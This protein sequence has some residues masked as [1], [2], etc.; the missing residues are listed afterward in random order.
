M[1]V[2][3]G[4]RIRNLDVL[5]PSR[6]KSRLRWK[7]YQVLSLLV[8]RTPE[9]VSRSEIIENIW[10]GTYCSDSTINQTI[11][12]IRQKIGDTE[13][14][15]IRT[16]PRLGYKI[17]NKDFFH[18]IAEEDDFIHNEALLSIETFQENIQG[19]LSE[20]E[21]EVND[22]PYVE[23]NAEG[24]VQGDEKLP[25]QITAKETVSINST[26]GDS[27]EASAF[28]LTRIIKYL[29][30]FVMLLAISHLSYVLGSRT[31][32]PTLHGLPN[33][34]RL[35]L[36]LTLNNPPG[37]NP[38]TLICLYREGSA[39]E[40]HIECVSPK[41]S[42]S[43]SHVKYETPIGRDKGNILKSDKTAYSQ[44]VYN[45]DNELPSDFTFNH[46]FIIA[47]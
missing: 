1:S 13:H 2:E 42:S 44:W 7:E 9:L 36:S 26:L 25:E 11:K 19:D 3:K 31:Q 23:I 27:K 15:L 18:F 33:T 6:K 43:K 8:A 45:S 16:I 32:S 12:S 14:T 40:M 20:K 10:K 4:I 30:A 41:E 29:A 21:S 34:S 37:A 46:N 28:P 22:E 35:V 39:R 5:I 47:E 17:E 24:K 38:Q